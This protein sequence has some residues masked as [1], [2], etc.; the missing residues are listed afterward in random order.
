[1][2]KKNSVP[3]FYVVLNSN[4]FFPFIFYTIA[5]DILKP[6]PHPT[7]FLDTLNIFLLSFNISVNFYD[8]YNVI[9]IPESII[10]VFNLSL[11]IITSILIIPSYV[12]LAELD[13]N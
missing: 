1:M 6:K 12:N 2:E 3:L 10:L 9:P 4:P 11:S 5:L 13:N 7:E 8:S